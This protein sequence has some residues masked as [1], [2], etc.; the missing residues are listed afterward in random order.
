MTVTIRHGKYFTLYSNLS[1][2]SVSK[3]QNVKAGQGL[4][5]VATDMDGDGSIEFILTKEFQNLN[6]QL[7]LRSR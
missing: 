2:I 7:W 5:R 4:G 6:P 1:S 3:G